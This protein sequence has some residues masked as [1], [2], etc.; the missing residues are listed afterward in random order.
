[1]QSLKG[2][3]ALITGGGRGIGRAVAIALANE[4]VNVGLIGMTLSNLEKAQQEIQ[5]LGVKASIV[6]VD[7]KDLNLVTQAVD[8]IQTELGAIDIVINNAGTAKFGKFL[9][10]TPEEW[11]NI[12]RVNL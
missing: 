11:E 4:G 3:V 1:M 6:A 7:V 8:R 5:A 2:K 12:I 9:E 10:L